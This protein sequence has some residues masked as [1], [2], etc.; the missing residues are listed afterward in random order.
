MV[1]ED[2]A[3][4]FEMKG[5]GNDTFHQGWQKLD[6]IKK[7]LKDQQFP[8]GTEKYKDS[9]QKLINASNSWVTWK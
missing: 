7:N 5:Y 1:F 6:E 8:Y 4:L 3:L 2:V 9:L